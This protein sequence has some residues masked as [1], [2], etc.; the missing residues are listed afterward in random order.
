MASDMRYDSRIQAASLFRRLEELPLGRFHVVLVLLVFV[1]VAFDNMD[2]VTL[3]F[4]IPA[5]S[6]EWGLT[7]NITRIHPIIG[8]GGTL[9]GAILFGMLADRI[10]RVN[11]FIWGIVIFAVTELANGFAPASVVVGF[12]WVLANCA[13]MGIGV[14]GAV[15]LAFTIISEYMPAKLRGRAVILVGVVSIGVGYLIAAAASWVLMPLF[16][17]RALFA[18]GFAPILL[19]PFIKKYIPES[20]RYLVSKGRMAEAVASVERIEVLSGINPGKAVALPGNPTPGATMATEVEGHAMET[21][22]GV[23]ELWTGRHRKRTVLTWLYGG[24]WGFFNFGFVVWFPSL[25]LTFGFTAGEVHSFTAIVDLIAIP[26][27]FLLAWLYD[28]WG[29]KPILTLFPLLGGA[30]TLL[31]GAMLAAG[32]RD[33]LLLAAPAIV[34]Y[35]AGLSLGGAFPSYAAEVYPTEVRGTGSGW[36]VGISRLTGVTALFL[37]GAWLA[38]GLDAREILLFLGIPLLLAGAGMAI[39][40]IETKKRT[41]EEIA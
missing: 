4:V 14:G 19:I 23:S 10:G 12:P 22:S 34:V 20:P 41:L 37:G 31:I 17:W 39:L 11:A 32:T 8:I 6:Q 27:G 18:I 16:G 9:V 13:I 3:S 40:G 7:P 30:A 25:L 2:V 26:L 24:G 28:R 33:I 36:A 29:R 15:P 21:M 35:S 5:Y 1:A 38:G